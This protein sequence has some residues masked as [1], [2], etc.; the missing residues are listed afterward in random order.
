MRKTKIVCT[1]GPA[2]DAP[3]MMAALVNGGMNVARFNFSHG[4]HEDHLVRANLVREQAAKAGKNVT[5]LLDTKG[6]EIRLGLF[7][8]GRAELVKGQK[9]TLTTTE[10][11]CDSTRAFVNY[12]GL[13]ADVKAGDTIMIDDG[14]INMTV[15]KV[16]GNDVVCVVHN[17]GVVTN[18]KKANVPDVALNLPSMT[19]QDKADI[20]FAAKNDFD[21]IAVSFVRKKE[22]L[23]EIYDFLKANGGEGIQLIAKIENREGVDNI[24]EII[25][26]GDGIMVARGDL[27]VEVP[28]EEI[29]LHQ[30]SIIEKCN[31]AGKVVITATQ[32]LESMVVNPR[33]TRAEVTDIANAVFDGTDATM[34]S[35][36]TAGGA[37]PIAAVETMAKIA[38]HTETNIDYWGEACFADIDEDDDSI[39][40][41]TAHAAYIAAANVKAGAIVAVTRNGCIARNIAKFRPACPVIAI[42]NNPR[43]YRQLNLSWGVVPVLVE[44]KTA[45]ELADASA[46]IALGTTL[47]KSGDKAVIVAM[48]GDCGTDALSGGIGVA[49]L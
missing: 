4:K 15:E 28:F 43:T 18:R 35:A 24:D 8:D 17:S 33:P 1:V 38:L 22:D 32:M 25:E 5:M 39:L 12:A 7:K 46:K 6:P 41:A 14:L 23:I 20:L 34:L 48:S 45:E 37:H 19:E 13:P 21:Y 36:E 26:T 49:K 47:V 11:E 42:T 29:P 31:A 30:K 16:D 27:G 2:V 40:N 44:G 10:C 3:E 9:F